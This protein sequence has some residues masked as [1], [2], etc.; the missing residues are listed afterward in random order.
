MVSIQLFYCSTGQYGIPKPFY[1]PFTKSYWCGSSGSNH[2]RSD[3][4][5]GMTNLNPRGKLALSG[6][7]CSKVNVYHLYT[8][9][10]L[11][12]PF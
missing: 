1:F 9:I 10:S 12:Y 3:N 4:Q 11:I 2:D 7:C 8:H 5:L 6:P